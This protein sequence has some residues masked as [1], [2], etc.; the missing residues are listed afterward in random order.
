MSLPPST[1]CL[2]S[3]LHSFIPLSLQPST[4]MQTCRW[5]YRCKDGKTSLQ[6]STRIHVFTAIYTHASRMSL[7]PSTLMHHKCL[8]SHLRSCITNVFTL[9]H[10]LM[11]PLTEEI[12]LK[13][14]GVPDWKVFLSK[15]VRD[16]NSSL[17]L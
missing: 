2:Y 16:G 1:Q 17:L 12:R 8:Y 10:S 14:F 7:Q 3:H 15:P 13:I 4:L 11:H 9:M 6:P 5:L